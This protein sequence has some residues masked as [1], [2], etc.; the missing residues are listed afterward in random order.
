M[1]SFV[2]FK[3]FGFWCQDENLR[4]WLSHAVLIL[5]GQR[6]DWHP[7]QQ[8]LYEEWNFYASLGCGGCLNLQLNELLI[9]Y[10][11][12]Q[13]SKSLII[14][15]DGKLI[16]YGASVPAA[17]LNH[18]PTKMQGLHWG[19]DRVTVDFRKV[20]YLLYRL[21]DGKLTTDAGS[22]LDYLQVENWRQL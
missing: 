6:K 21:L 11:K 16:S 7:W 8:H 20:G 22:P 12:I 14:K 17:I 3:D 1:V 18:W 13:A 2:E 5:S 15:I 10:D 19:A 4:V 9:G